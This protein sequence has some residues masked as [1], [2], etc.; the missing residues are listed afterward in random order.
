M[1]AFSPLFPHSGIQCEKCGLTL[2]INDGENNVVYHIFPL[3]V[4]FE[5]RFRRVFHIDWI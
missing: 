5:A 2:E 1:L 4:R 3:E